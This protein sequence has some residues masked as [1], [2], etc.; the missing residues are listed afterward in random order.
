MKKYETETETKTRSSF[1]SIVKTHSESDESFPF[2]AKK[3][4]TSFQQ[5]KSNAINF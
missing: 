5:K 3:I 4:G 1:E 2:K